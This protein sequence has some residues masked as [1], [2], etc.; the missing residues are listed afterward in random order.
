V[1]AAIEHL[2]ADNTAGDPMGGL[3]WTRKTT[4]GVSRE[5]R[6]AGIQVS[7][8]TVGRLLSDLGYALRVNHKKRAARGRH[9]DRN[10]QFE[11]IAGRRRSFRRRNLPV[12]SVDTKKKELIG[13][14]K[15]AGST[16]R[17]T[18]EEVYD[19][20][21]RSDAQGIGIPYGNY[22]ETCNRGHIYVGT[23]HD[24][25]CFAAESISRWWGQDGQSRHPEAREILILADSGG[26]NGA[27]NN[28]WKHEVQTKLSDAHGLRVTICHY[29]PGTSKWNPVEHRLFS[30]ISKHWAGQPLESY[31]TMLNFLRTTRTKTGLKV[32]ATLITREYQ[33]GLKPT[34]EQMENLNLRG[35]R[36]LPAWN[37]TIS[38]R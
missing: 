37:Y 1:I 3:R 25:A 10:R 24:T 30:E 38:P 32:R 5:L 4:E 12:I 26:S 16:W 33:T 19:H 14:F 7:P 8:K 36:T 27:R 34:S 31:E 15:N 22:E 18:A 23:S 9:P 20:D 29:P 35:H 28:A 13:H 2:L 21:F 17:K 6:S 11:Y